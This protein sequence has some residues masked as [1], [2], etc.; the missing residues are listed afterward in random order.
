MTCTLH[1]DLW[2]FMVTSRSILLRM[3]VFQTNVVVQKINPLNPELNPIRCLLALLGAHHFLHVSR[4]RVKTHF[5]FNNCFFS[6][7]VPFMR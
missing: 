1:E 6:K 5:M 2:T 3:R 7:I 4:I